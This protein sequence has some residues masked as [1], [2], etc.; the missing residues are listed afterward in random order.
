[1]DAKGVCLL[2][3]EGLWISLKED[4]FDKSKVKYFPF[5]FMKTSDGFNEIYKLV[6]KKTLIV[7]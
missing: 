1:M 2:S 7:R 3:R 6:S 4:G 5:K